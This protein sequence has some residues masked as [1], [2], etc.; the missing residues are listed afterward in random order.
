[1][2]FCLFETRLGHS[3][4]IVMR[5]VIQKVLSASV[6]VDNKLISKIGKGVM[7]IRDDDDKACSELIA[8]KILVRN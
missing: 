3:D 1:M 6:S 7:C 5:V 4:S 2:N 8:K